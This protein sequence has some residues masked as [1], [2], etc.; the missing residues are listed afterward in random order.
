M[1]YIANIL[2]DKNFSDKELYNV[3]KRKEDLIDGI[4]TLIV[5]WEFTKSLYPNADMFEWEIED[6]VY[7]TYGFR[8]RRNKYEVQVEKF[9]KI[10]LKHF[11]QSINYKFFNVL[12]CTDEEKHE[13]FM[14]IKSNP[15]CSVYIKNN[16]VYIYDYTNTVIGVYLYDIDYIGKNRK[17]F[18][19]MLY[20]NPNAKFINEDNGLS[21]EM[22]NAL[23]NYKYIMPYLYA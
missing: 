11:V 13:F 16:M 2:T 7:W 22:K 4:P 17:Q 20:K 3:V 12:S 10:A 6:N 1:T 8:E 21:I 18:L 14:F 5:G 15:K 23:R 19:A 9:R